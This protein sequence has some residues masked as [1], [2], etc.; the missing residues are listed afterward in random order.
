M[1][2]ERKSQP[3]GKKPAEA[4]AAES[5]QHAYEAS[6]CGIGGKRLLD[7]AASRHMQNASLPVKR[8]HGVAADERIR[9]ATGRILDAP[10]KVDID[11]NLENG[12]KFELKNVLTHPEL[13]TS[14]VSVGALLEDPAVK[15]ISFGRGGAKVQDHQGRV[16][17]TARRENGVFV[18]NT[19]C[20]E[21]STDDEDV[22]HAPETAVAAAGESTQDKAD[23]WHQRAC[24]LSKSTMMD[25][26]RTGAVI[27]SEQWKR[28]ANTAG[29]LLCQPCLEGKMKKSPIGDHMREELKAR[30]V[31]ER[32]HLDTS[33]PFTPGLNGEKYRLN[34][35]D[36]FSGDGHVLYTCSKDEL[37]KVFIAWVKMVQNKLNLRIAE[38]RSDGGGEFINKAVDAWCTENGTN[39]HWG[40]TDTPHL[41]GRAERFQQTIDNL[42]VA[43][44]H[45]AGAPEHLWVYASRHA[46]AAHNRL[47]I[48]SGDPKRTRHQV[49]FDIK[50]PTSVSEFKVWGCRAYARKP[51]ESG[52]NKLTAKAIPCTNLG[53]SYQRSSY[54]LIDD[55]G[56]VF[57]SRDVRF[58]EASFAGMRELTDDDADADE[59]PIRSQSGFQ[60]KGDAA[61]AKLLSRDAL[62]APSPVASRQLPEL[63]S[64][65]LPLLECE[66]DAGYI[67]PEH[68]E[69]KSVSREEI[70]AAD[71]IEERGDL[72]IKSR[73][74]TES[75]DDDD[76]NPE[77][78]ADEPEYTVERI[79]RKRQTKN[80]GEQYLVHWQ[81][82]KKPTWEPAEAMR[83]QVPN[84]VEK[85][86]QPSEEENGSVVPIVEDHPNVQDSKNG[87]EVSISRPRRAP[88]PFHRL[89]MADPR[90]YA[91]MAEACVAVTEIHPQSE[92]LGDPLSYDAILERPDREQ[93]LGAHALE[94][95]AQMKNGTYAIVP[96][97]TIPPGIRL[98]T[99]KDVYKLKTGPD[100]R[101]SKYKARFTI[102]GCAQS[103]DQYGD[104]TAYVF[105]MRSLRV[106]CA[107]VAHYDWEFKQLDVDAAYLHGELKEEL[108]AVA[109]K[110]LGIPSDHAV[111]LKK[112]IYG[113]K[114]AAH[115]WQQTLFRE[116]T[117]LNYT[118]LRWSDRCV[119]IRKLANGRMLIIM[120]YVDDIPYAY[121]K[122]DEREMQGDI[123]QLMSRFPIKDLGNAEYILG[124]R[125]TRD[126]TN[127]KLMLDQQGNIQHLLEEY[128]MTQCLPTESPGTAVSVLHRE[129]IPTKTSQ[130]STALAQKHPQVQ[131]KDYRAIIGS[132]QYLASCTL[133]VI[134][135]AVN[136]LAQF[137]A[138]PQTHHLIA[139]KKILHYLCSHREDRLVYTGTARSG[140]LS[141]TAYT[142]ADFAEDPMTRKSTTGWVVMLCGAAISWRSKRQSTVARSTMEAEY[143][144]A[145]S[146]VDELIAVRRLL[147]ELGCPQPG[148]TIVR[149]DNTASI[150][151]AKEGGKEERRKHIDVKHHCIV[152]AIDNQV[153]NLK[154]IPSAD[155]IADLFTKPL[156]DARYRILKE[157]VLGQAQ[158]KN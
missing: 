143:V 18:V 17:M 15:V 48:S 58:D 52:D 24:H 110:G 71:A 122:R 154:W 99:W 130:S 112:T 109:P 23:L 73:G 50:K 20:G 137:S 118:A 25:T 11:L 77:E 9:V 7:S 8:D 34:I 10:K 86:E 64:D 47:M 1:I 124:W 136:K 104:I 128:G 40:P 70:E 78:E 61:L 51:E 144:A 152:E 39:P 96:K 116:L 82:Y 93:W 156:P 66:P 133:P 87:V 49:F 89:G 146:I 43:A 16:V 38:L 81:G 97:S 121:D 95:E 74:P 105:S 84:F 113:L 157:A 102:R 123:Q 22:G 92:Q 31:L 108:Y 37:P 129:G 103:P 55:D 27:E 134:A 54:T 72:D 125:I 101:P 139:L 56:R 14:L 45:A 33:G 46:V 6:V 32:L 150:A 107:L 115:E 88:K 12:S 149:I 53:Y 76:D 127:R 83:A 63:A 106:I 131:L 4:Q 119:F 140:V 75:E 29:S 147:S 114:Q 135:D 151:V 91:N 120:V 19:A 158:A 42:Q 79:S 100:G 155:N 41:N 85:F 35:V 148:P 126:R 26:A 132:L 69:I 67:D 59:H 36:E 117:K 57:Q 111:K 141:V 5:T 145:A 98:L 3:S 30:R 62:R 80:G 138:D 68:D 44:M 65:H 153:I 28:T 142:D 2:R 94:H 90:D 13:R 60:P 21:R